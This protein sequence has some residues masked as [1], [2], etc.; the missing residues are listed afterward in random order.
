MLYGMIKRVLTKSM[1]NICYHR[2]RF[3]VIHL[4][5]FFRKLRTYFTFAI[6]P[7]G[8]G[9]YSW[10]SSG[11]QYQRF[12]VQVRKSVILKDQLFSGEVSVVIKQKNMH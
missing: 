8:F 5:F 2:R 3:T 9:R 7:S 1:L 10:Q 11:F 12:V 4:E 6:L